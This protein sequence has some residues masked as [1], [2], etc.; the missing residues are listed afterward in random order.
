ML[1]RV[2]LLRFLPLFFSSVLSELA[3]Q[4]SAVVPSKKIVSPPADEL[5]PGRMCKIKGIEKCLAQV[6]AEVRNGEA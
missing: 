2:Y 3:G 1:N 5:T 4:K 6:L